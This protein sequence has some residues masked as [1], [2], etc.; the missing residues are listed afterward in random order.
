M[1]K[2]A[3]FVRDIIMSVFTMQAESFFYFVT[4]AVIADLPPSGPS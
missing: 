4:V 1:D 3:L 2:N